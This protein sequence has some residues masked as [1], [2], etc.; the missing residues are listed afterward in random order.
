M[1]DEE[2]NT[3]P[4][5][6]VCGSNQKQDVT[7]KPTMEIPGGEAGTCTQSLSLSLCFFESVSLCLYVCLTFSV[8]VYYS[9]FIVGNGSSADWYLPFVTAAD[10]KVLEHS[11][12]LQLLLEILHWAEELQ[13]KV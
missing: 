10:A 7:N 2:G 12:K 4:V 5:S 13:D 6:S 11:G 1:G 3:D 8:S 9:G